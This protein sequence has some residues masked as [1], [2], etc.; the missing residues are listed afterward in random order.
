[1]HSHADSSTPHSDRVTKN[2][3][4]GLFKSLA[5]IIVFLIVMSWII[6]D[7]LKPK[8]G[9]RPTRPTATKKK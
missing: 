9:Q 3:A 2:T 8:E 7:S 1:M 4:A 6:L 5:A